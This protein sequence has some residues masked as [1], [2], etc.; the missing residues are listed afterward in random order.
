MTLVVQSQNTLED[1]EKWV[2]ESFK[3][4]PNNGLKRESFD[5]MTMPFET[6]R[7]NKVYK[8]CPIENIFEVRQVTGFSDFCDQICT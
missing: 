8:M 6:D 3:A 1:L 4:V 7:F 5:H 2:L